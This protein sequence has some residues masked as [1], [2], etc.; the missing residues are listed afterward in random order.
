MAISKMK[1]VLSQ[2]QSRT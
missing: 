1:N 2:M